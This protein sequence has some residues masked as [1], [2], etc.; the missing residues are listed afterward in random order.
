MKDS[1]VI[2]RAIELCTNRPGVYAVATVLRKTEPDGP[3]Q[4]DIKTKEEA[5][6]IVRFLL[7]GL[8]AWKSLMEQCLT[9]GAE[10]IRQLLW[11]EAS[12]S[13]FSKNYDNWVLWKAEITGLAKEHDSII[14]SDYPGRA[15]SSTLGKLAKDIN[16]Y[17]RLLTE[18]KD[19]DYPFPRPFTHE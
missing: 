13:Q 3:Q 15:L 4:V 10:D 5:Y 9:Q 18:F 8:R 7:G 2:Y 12:S 11:N 6:K 16:Y 17:E 19:N 14:I 1:F